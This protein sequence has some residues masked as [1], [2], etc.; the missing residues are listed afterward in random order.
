MTINLYDYYIE[1]V[2]ELHNYNELKIEEVNT[3]LINI[4]FKCYPTYLATLE[5]DEQYST[6][7]RFLL[8]DITDDVETRTGGWDK[9]LIEL[10]L[11]EKLGIGII[12][13][14]KFIER[15]LYGLTVFGKTK[16][17]SN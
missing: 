8:V 5:Y 11:D 15:I 1:L 10:S 16:N 7:V 17:A 9:P 3:D 2:N 12:D 13:S 6:Y 14:V 4:R